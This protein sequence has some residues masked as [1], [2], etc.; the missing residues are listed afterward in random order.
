MLSHFL[1]QSIPVYSSEITLLSPQ[2]LGGTNCQSFAIENA[3]VDREFDEEWAVQ[4]RELLDE[5]QAI[6]GMFHVFVLTLQ[7]HRGNLLC[8]LMKIR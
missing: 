6:T 5:L 8:K 3:A 7:R 1:G 4:Y 2:A